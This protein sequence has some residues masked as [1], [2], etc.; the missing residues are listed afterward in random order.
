MNDAFPDIPKIQYEGPKS[1]NALSFKHYN[2]DEIVGGKTMRSQM[3]FA[4]AYWHAMRNSLSD[5]FGGGTAQR[6]WDDGSNSVANAQRRVWACFEFMDKLGVDYYCW[7]DRDV[8]PELDTLAESNAAFDAVADELEKAQKQT[9]KK[10][11]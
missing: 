7:H 11:L 3:R 2:P 5:P 8:A 9:G 6:P 4:V 1:R 10:L